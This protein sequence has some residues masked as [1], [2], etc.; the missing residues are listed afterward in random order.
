MLF[1]SEEAFNVLFDWTFKQTLNVLVLIGIFVNLKPRMFVFAL[2]FI[3][4]FLL[5]FIVFQRQL[6]DD[7]KLLRVIF[8]KLF[9]KLK[10]TLHLG[11]AKLDRLMN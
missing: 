7:I 2:L 3:F 1:R 10:T 5:F 8:K 9:V 6:G 11:I 4:F